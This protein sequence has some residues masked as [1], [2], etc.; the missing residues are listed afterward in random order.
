MFLAPPCCAPVCPTGK[1]GC[2]DFCLKIDYIIPHIIRKA[3]SPTL[4][5]T[6]KGGQHMLST[7]FFFRSD[8]LQRDCFSA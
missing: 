5:H 6:N 7:P 8:P 1:E 3:L 4:F 2:A